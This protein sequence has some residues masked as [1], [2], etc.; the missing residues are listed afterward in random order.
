M[1]FVEA[2]PLDPKHCEPGGGV[3]S[4]AVV[5][6]V[7]EIGR[8]R[9][10]DL[11]LECGAVSSRHARI[12]CKEQRLI[13]IDLRSGGGTLVDGRRIEAPVIIGAESTIVMGHYTLRV[14]TTPLTTTRIPAG[15]CPRCLGKLVFRNLGDYCPRC[16]WVLS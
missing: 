14:S 4:R 1:L 3:I 5:R 13:L 7:I 11:T 6:D 2:I 10:C 15:S 9:E 8:A 12:L 16:D